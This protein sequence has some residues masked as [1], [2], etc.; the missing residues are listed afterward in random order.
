M[1]AARCSCR[2]VLWS[3]LRCNP[4]LLTICPIQIFKSSG[5]PCCA[6]GTRNS[7]PALRY[8]LLLGA[9][10]STSFA[11]YAAA[12]QRT[13]ASRV[14]F[15]FC[16]MRENTATRPTQPPPNTRTHARARTHS[17]TQRAQLQV[18]AGLT[19][20]CWCRAFNAPPFHSRSEC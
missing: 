5:L 7:R 17:Q 6:A 2:L 16:K 9:M 1:P 12:L 10:F 14:A 15:V 18:A 20:G 4:M 11:L 13:S 19:S 8:G 3:R